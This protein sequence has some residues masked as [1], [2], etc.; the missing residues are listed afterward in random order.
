MIVYFY[1]SKEWLPDIP[2]NK[3]PVQEGGGPEAEGG[4]GGGDGDIGSGLHGSGET[5]D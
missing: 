4:G 1:P 3:V 5:E 2:K